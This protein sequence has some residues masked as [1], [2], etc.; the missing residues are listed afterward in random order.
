MALAVQA[1]CLFQLA[2]ADE[3]PGSDYIRHDVDLQGFL[4]HYVLHRQEA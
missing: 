3:A 4:A 2:L 1:Q